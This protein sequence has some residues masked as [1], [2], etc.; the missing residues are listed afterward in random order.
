MKRKIIL[1]FIFLTLFLSKANA[2][3]AGVPDTLAYL[4]TIVA[5]KAQYIGQ[6]F[7]LL[8]NH[9]QMEVKR[10]GP[11]GNIHHNKDLETSTSFSFYCPTSTNDSYRIFPALRVMWYPYLNNNLSMS[12]FTLFGG[13]WAPQ[14]YNHYADAVIRDID[15]LE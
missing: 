7:S 12:M 1:G 4:R 3:T 11:A 9:L 6:P 8:I 15:I 10:F 2:Q 5:N 14:V 13:C